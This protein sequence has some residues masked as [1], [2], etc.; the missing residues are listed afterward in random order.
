VTRSEGYIVPAG[1]FR[2]LEIGRPAPLYRRGP[3]RVLFPPLLRSPDF[4]RA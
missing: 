4:V 1:E 2:S 3:S